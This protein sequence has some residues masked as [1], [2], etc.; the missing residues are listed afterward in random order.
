MNTKALKGW[1]TVLAVVE[2]LLCAMIVL[3]K[4][5]VPE[6]EL[7]YALRILFVGLFM[8]VNYPGLAL[9]N[10]VHWGPDCYPQAGWVVVFGFNM[11]VYATC[12]WLIEA[13]AGSR[14]HPSGQ[15]DADGPTGQRGSPPSK[16]K[17]RLI[18]G[19]I[20]VL[21]LGGVFA[22][23]V[24]GKSKGRCAAE[25]QAVVE[26]FLRT[27]GGGAFTNNG[28]F[29]RLEGTGYYTPVWNIQGYYYLGLNRT[30]HFSRGS[31]P[32]TIFVTE[33]R[34]TAPGLK[35]VGNPRIEEL[36]PGVRIF[37]S[38]PDLK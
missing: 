20:G 38:H 3:M 28:L 21:L 19:F 12:I 6:N 10:A 34:V 22:L 1:I 4:D 29:L 5:Y 8:A 37:V 18:A 23:V 9:A 14:Q 33:G 11:V 35:T 31:L 30:A 7:L 27:G 15:R 32:I 24:C 16:P 2:A 36:S 17:G 25:A 13:W 26:T